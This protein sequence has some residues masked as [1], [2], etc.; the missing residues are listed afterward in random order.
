MIIYW[1]QSYKDFVLKLFSTLKKEKAIFVF[2]FN[3]YAYF[4]K[5]LYIF[6]TSTL[7][8]LIVSETKF[9][10][11]LVEHYH[12]LIKNLSSIDIHVCMSQWS[13]PRD[14]MFFVKLKKK[15]VGLL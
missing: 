10:F 3:N 9:A 7:V 11:F 5:S 8:L 14:W 12:L 13:I 1:H 2:N 6:P 4:Q 15:N